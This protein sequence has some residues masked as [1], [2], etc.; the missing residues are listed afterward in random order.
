MK[1]GFAFCRAYLEHWSGVKVVEGCVFA[2][3]LILI[4][5]FSIVEPLREKIRDLEKRY[6]YFLFCINACILVIDLRRLMSYASSSCE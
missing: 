5:L 3:K 4:V 6:V 1:V 2:L